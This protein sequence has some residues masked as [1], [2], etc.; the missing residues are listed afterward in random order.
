MRMETQFGVLERFI[1]LKNDLT[2]KEVYAQAPVFVSANWKDSNVDRALI[3]IQGTGE[4]RAGVWSRKALINDS[5]DMGSML[6]QLKYAQ[7]NGMSCLVMNPNY[8]KDDS[9]KAVDPRINTMEKHCRY[10][11]KK[12]VINRCQ[13]KEIYIIAHSRGGKCLVDLFKRYS[14]D[15]IDKVKAVAFT[16]SVHD[17]FKGSLVDKEEEDWI[18]NNCIHFVKSAKK[19]GKEEKS[20]DG[21]MIDTY[22]AGHTEHEYTTGSSWPKIQ[23]FFE[24]QSDKKLKKCEY[25]CRS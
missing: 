14:I 23:K 8:H 24:N 1:P 11:F 15:F 18:D 3:L 4:V 13:A 21:D 17:N 6:P 12:Y 10:V 25:S 9:G 16:D 20:T 22:S 19:L 2:D 5:L 7:E